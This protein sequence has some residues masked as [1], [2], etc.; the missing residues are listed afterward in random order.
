MENAF[1]SPPYYVRQ[2][3]LA[4]RYPMIL[5]Y[6]MGGGL[7]HLTRA[8]AVL[9][10]LGIERDVVILTA[11]HF[12]SDKRVIGN[13]RV[14][15]PPLSLARDLAA[16][17]LWFQHQLDHLE[18]E[19]IYLDT[20]PAGILGELCDFPPLEGI[21]IHYLARLLKWDEYSKLLQGDPPCFASTYLLEPLA[22]EHQAFIQQRSAQYSS[23]TLFDPPCEL[24]QRE[25]E[26]T[27][28][29]CCEDRPLWLVVHSGSNE[30]ISE[31][32]TY[33]EEM[34][35]IEEI[36]AHIILI[37]P[38]ATYE[39][40]ANVRHIDL[41]PASSLFSIADRIISACGY[42]VMRQ[43]ASYRER[44]QFMPFVRRFDDQ[45]TR[46]SRE[47]QSFINQIRMKAL[48]TTKP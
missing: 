2:L 31:L 24:D 37:A 19:E 22:E 40:L 30:E 23:L 33:A 13:L 39:L 21:P 20:F 45:F 38:E 8:R 9:H 6:A 35:C 27:R 36:D 11:S 7:G 3:L 26:I 5:Y 17:R 48:A 16:F 47:R 4:K 41:Y 34:R 25:Q 42:N 46:A 43:L 12:A 32:V 44:H 15:Y 10:T 28:E 18:P 14:I 29:F 1:P